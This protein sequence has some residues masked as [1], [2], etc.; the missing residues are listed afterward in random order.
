MYYSI[1]LINVINSNEQITKKPR[2]KSADMV[3]RARPPTRQPN[4]FPLG[5]ESFR[6]DNDRLTPIAESN[7][8][9]PIRP[10]SRHQYG[11]KDDH[12]QKSSYFLKYIRY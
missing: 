6:T 8:T 5:L 9:S 12:H 10:P 3:S 2:F 11:R 1:S 7:S 4:A